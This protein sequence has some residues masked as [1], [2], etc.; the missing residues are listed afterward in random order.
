MNGGAR[1]PGGLRG[2][3]V[4]VAAVGCLHVRQRHEGRFR[5]LFQAAAGRADVLLLAGDLTERGT[6]AEA[7]VVAGEVGGLP[8]PVVAVLGNHDHLGGRPDQVG[9]VLADAGVMVLDYSGV[10][11]SAGGARVGI[12]GG[13][14]WPGGFGDGAQAGGED[15]VRDGRRLTAALAGLD[16]DVRI[17][18]THY[19]PVVDTLA[20][21]PLEL[22]PRL[23]SR[24]LGEAVDS[25]GADLVVHGH[26][27][28]GVEHG[29][30]ASGAP[31]RNVARAV[32][33]DAYRVYA[34]RPGQ[35]GVST[36]PGGQLAGLGRWWWHRSTDLAVRALQVARPPRLPGRGRGGDRSL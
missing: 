2:G 15:R 24:S 36:V 16:C 34:L 28:R 9:E 23:G 27:H 18:L 11:V 21:E 4:R 20:G 1:V 29:V 12:A 22:Y 32:I 30:T 13:M 17:A 6:V 26:A 35:P 8:V 25:A 19:A 3:Q 5:R 31:V 7:R 33:R 10:V 14:G